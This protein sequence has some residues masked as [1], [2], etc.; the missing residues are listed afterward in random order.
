MGNLRIPPQ[1]LSVGSLGFV[2]GWMSRGGK[3]RSKL[4]GSAHLPA[5]ALHVLMAAFPHA[6]ITLGRQVAIAGTVAVV[7]GI[8]VKFMHH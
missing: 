7:G 6:A 4:I 1:Y 8:A 3:L 5:V 2:A